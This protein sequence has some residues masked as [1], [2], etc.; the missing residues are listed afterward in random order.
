MNFNILFLMHA[1]DPLGEAGKQ[2][3]NMCVY[4][5]TKMANGG[6]HDHIGQV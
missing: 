6:I 3:L 5:L 2:C 4:T 1:R